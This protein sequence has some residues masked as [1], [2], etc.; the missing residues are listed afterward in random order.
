M[1]AII[2]E[3]ELIASKRLKRLINEL[4]PSIQ[5]VAS[6]QSVFDTADYLVKNEMPDLMFLDIQVMDGLSLELFDIVDITANVIFTTAYDEYAVQAFRKNAVDYLLK[7]IKKEE[8]KEAIA[9]IKQFKKT[10]LE[11]L[12]ETFASYR[13]RFLIKFGA[14]LHSVPTE[15]IAYIYSENK[16]SYFILKDGKRIASDFKLKDLINQL[17]PKFF[18]RIN[19]QYIIHIDAIKNMLTYSKSRIKLTLEPETKSEVIIS[20]ETTPKFKAWLNR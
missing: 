12:E 5:V 7:P 9:R 10:D 17:N 20:T 18:F 3:D 19:R 4:Q 14:K 11:N 8:L 16:I 13:N 2:L 1:K 15:E 6:F